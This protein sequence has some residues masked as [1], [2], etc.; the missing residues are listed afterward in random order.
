MLLNLPIQEG[1]SPNTHSNTGVNNKHSTENK[2]IPERNR[3][4]SLNFNLLNQNTNNIGNATILNLT[5][6]AHVGTVVLEGD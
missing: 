2:V 5:H 1:I 3:T 4:F 6:D